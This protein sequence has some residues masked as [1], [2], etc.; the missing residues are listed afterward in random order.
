MRQLNGVYT[1]TYNLTHNITGHLFQGRYKS[2]LVD[3]DNY[4]LEL[5]RY[6]V[7]NPVRAGMVKHADQ[8]KWSSYQA[9][10]GEALAPDWLSCG[11]LL[12]QFI[13][14]SVNLRSGSTGNS[15][16]KAYRYLRYRRDLSPEQSGNMNK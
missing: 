13:V 2:I 1:Q 11:S 4:L 16:R 12:S 8:W 3:E 10:T 9:M 5:S 14:R 6:I 7:L 15:C